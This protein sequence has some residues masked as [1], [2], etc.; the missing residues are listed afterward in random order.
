[1]ETL[2]DD[3]S[4]IL[5]I[6]SLFPSSNLNIKDIYNISD[7]NLNK[8]LLLLSK[9]GWLIYIDKE[10]YKIHQI[11]KEF[12][13][14]NFPLRCEHV[15]PMIK[16]N[17]KCIR[18]N[19]VEHPKNQQRYMTFAKSLIDGLSNSDD[20]LIM[21]SNNLAMLYRYFGYFELALKYMI[22]VKEYDENTGDKVSLAQTYNNLGQ[23]YSSMKNSKL[24]KKYNLLSLN[25]RKEHSSYNIQ[26]N[27]LSICDNAIRE[28]NY[29]EAKEYLDKLLSMKTD[30]KSIIPIYNSAILYYLNIKDIDKA[31]IYVNKALDKIN[32]GEVDSKHLYIAYTYSNISEIYIANNNLDLA[33]E[34]RLKAKEHILKN[35]GDTHPDLEYINKA[36]TTL[37][38]INKMNNIF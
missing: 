27:Y 35:F 11:I 22:I 29:I 15:V 34:Y 25:I 26:E 33:I 16:N 6:F 8:E 13:L 5:M 17:L 37:V 14:Y 30:I 23:V 19:E 31:F 4:N 7:L 28:E 32:N 12:L 20:G 2:D 21:L 10:T 38:D 36:L 1:M 3:F 9:K 18:W 24:A